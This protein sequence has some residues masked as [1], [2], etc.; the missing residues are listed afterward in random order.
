[1]SNSSPKVH[2][3]AYVVPHPLESKMQLRIETSNGEDPSLALK[4]SLNTLI[5]TCD[6]FSDKFE[7]RLKSFKK[8]HD[9][10]KMEH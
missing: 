4:N 10:E 5:S 2:V 6:T 7:S 3:A 1:M 9:D 8:R